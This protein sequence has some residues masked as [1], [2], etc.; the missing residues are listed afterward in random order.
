MMINIFY[1]AIISIII[2]YMI[3]NQKDFFFYSTNKL[4]KYKNK[5]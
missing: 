1:I 4:I 5:I 2:K 3:R